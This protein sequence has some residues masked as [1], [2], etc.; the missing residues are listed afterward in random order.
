MATALACIVCKTTEDLKY[1][2]CCNLTIYCGLKCQL[3]DRNNH[4]TML[5]RR[6]NVK[7]ATQQMIMIG[8]LATFEINVNKMPFKK[9]EDRFIIKMNDE[10]QI[11]AVQ[12]ISLCVILSLRD[13]G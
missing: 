13:L 4:I 1:C 9:D 8:E 10:T 2:M 6:Q 5:A 7:L 11:I 12:G 3:I